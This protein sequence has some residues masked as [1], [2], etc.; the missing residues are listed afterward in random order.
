MNRQKIGTVLFWVGA[1]CVIVFYILLWVGNA[2]HRVTTPAE[3]TGTT[4]AS[5]GF[6]FIFRGMTGIIGAL[7]ALIGVMLYS[8]KK[9]SFFWLWG[10]VPFLAVFLLTNWRP[11]QYSP[12]L[13]GIGG[14]IITLSYLGVLWAWLKTHAAYEGI[15]KTGKHIQLLGYFFM[16]M[17]GLFLCLY[18]GMPNLPGLADQPVPSGESILVLFTAG[19]V[20]LAVGH[21]MSG[22]R[23][24]L[25]RSS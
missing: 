10:F 19:W 24:D 8:G 6:L 7:L 2:V 15:A 23:Q 3:L 18:V 5:D 16:F 4:W 12:I 9:G 1:V 17:T 13:Y 20:L 21:Y 25:Y 22:M 14:G 11:S